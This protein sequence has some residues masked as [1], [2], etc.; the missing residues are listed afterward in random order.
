MPSLGQAGVGLGCVETG[1]M[2][3]CSLG[4][5][6]DSQLRAVDPLPGRVTQL[7]ACGY[8]QHSMDWVIQG[9]RAI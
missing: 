1:N 3:P 8:T 4:N 5:I 2:G 7:D 6:L 9:P